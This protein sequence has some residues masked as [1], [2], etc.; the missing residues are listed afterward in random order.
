MNIELKEEK[1]KAEN[2]LDHGLAKDV[3]KRLPLEARGSKA[4]RYNSDDP[5][6]EL[7][8]SPIIQVGMGTKR[9]RGSRPNREAVNNPGLGGA[10]A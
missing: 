6:P 4:S 2:Y 8:R 10:R 7:P 3:D 1:E 9:Q 5:A